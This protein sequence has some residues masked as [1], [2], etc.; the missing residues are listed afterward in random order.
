M[1]KLNKTNNN[2]LSKFFGDK[3]FVKLFSK[4]FVPS[5]LQSIVTILILYI[6]NFAIATLIKDKELANAAKEALGLANPLVNFQLLFICGWLNGIGIMLSQYYGN[7]DYNAVR[8]SICVRL[9][10]S[11]I[12]QIPIILVISIIPGKLIGITTGTYNGEVHYLAQIYLFFTTFTFIPLAMGM[13]LSYSLKETKKAWVAFFAS[14]AGATTNAILDPI[15]I[16]FSDNIETTIAF[17]AISTGISRLVQFTFITVY[18]L[19]RKDLYLWYFKSW[20]ISIKKLFRIIKNGSS[21]FINEAVFAFC[22]MLLMVCM[23]SFNPYVHD[24][25]TNLML[26]VQFT[27]C[28][29]P[30]MSTAASVLVGS[31]LGSGNVKKAKHNANILLVWGISMST[32][33]GILLFVLAC[34]INPILSPAATNEMNTLSRNLEWVMTPILIT[35]GVS[36]IAYYSANSGGSK[37]VVVIDGGITLIW[38]IMMMPLTLTGVTKNMD[39]LAYVFLLESNQ[40]VKMIVGLFVFKFSN[41]AKVLTQTKKQEMMVW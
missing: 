28:I 29:W 13:T 2:I 38:V 32:F 11:F 15:V 23:L 12:V 17:V 24:A 5:A 30:G 4:L 40:I 36:A 31:E 18:I 1:T 34:F 33:L 16:I 21:T 8:Q 19:W 22:N 20:K 6:D 3:E 9:W 7:K 35:Q 39:P 10:S 26:I 25:T 41:W 37:L 27:T 14:C